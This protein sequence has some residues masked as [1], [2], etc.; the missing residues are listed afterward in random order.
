M[1]G[2]SGLEDD[3]GDRTRVRVG[4]AAEAL[5]WARMAPQV[6]DARQGPAL[7][8]E[9]AIQAGE[10]ASFFAGKLVTYSKDMRRTPGGGWR[11]VTG[12]IRDGIT[13]DLLLEP[14]PSA[15]REGRLRV[16]AQ[17]T[18]T[19][20]G[21][22][23]PVLHVRPSREASAVEL[24]RPQ[25]SSTRTKATFTL[26]LQGG[27]ALLALGGIGTTPGDQVILILRIQDL[28]TLGK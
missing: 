20:V 4:S 28:E 5:T 24:E 3:P 16:K 2:A 10:P 27:G 21:L 7:Q 19:E 17:V 9:P 12:T 18:R 15:D 13:L 11:I 22:P 1:R 14:T 6:P 23:M 8:G 25:W 26:P